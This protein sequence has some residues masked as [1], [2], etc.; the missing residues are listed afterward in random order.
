MTSEEI[1]NL[2]SE[3]KRLA[4]KPTVCPVCGKR[5]YAMDDSG[6]WLKDYE[7]KSCE[8]HIAGDIIF[9]YN[10]GLN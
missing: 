4:I 5:Y 9:G 7:I 8:Q 3:M 1:N 10:V 6:N 2:V